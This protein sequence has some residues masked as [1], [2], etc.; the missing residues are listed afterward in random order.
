MSPSVKADAAVYNYGKLEKGGIAL[1]GI[2]CSLCL[3]NI[4]KYILSVSGYPYPLF[5]TSFHMIV[6]FFVARWAIF[7]AEL[8][9]EF[10][11]LSVQDQFRKILPIC[12][13]QVLSIG[14]NNL[15]LL[16]LYP[17][18]VVILGNSLPL[19]TLAFG[20]IMGTEGVSCYSII[21]IALILGSSMASTQTEA[22]FHFGGFILMMLCVSMRAFKQVLQAKILRASDKIDPLT[23]LYYVAP[24]SFVLFF[25]WSLAK[26]G[27]EPIAVLF[28]MPLR[29]WL[30]IIFSA[31]VASCFNV[32]AFLGVRV[33]NATTWSLLG[34]MVSPMTALVSFFL[35]G[36][37]IS[38]AQVVSYGLSGV[39]VIL[40][41][42]KGKAKKQEN[43]HK[44]DDDD[45]EAS[46]MGAEL[47]VIGD[48]EDEDELDIF[49]DDEKAE[50]ASLVTSS[51]GARI[52]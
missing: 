44:S 6:S 22:N 49:L 43:A 24:Q 37:A 38:A 41:Q 48:G 28:E 27:L 45:L 35:F 51:G 17:S 20:V 30:L 32:V 11:E 33:L 3:S 19:F 10:R 13:C 21:A 7:T 26:D 16:F 39:G 14:F 46:R 9:N 36:N 5:L 4:I 1:A 50:R 31:M 18:F 52:N 47:E 2:F 42:T 12:I 34:Q 29:T 8:P 25:L 15:A 40:Y 23:L